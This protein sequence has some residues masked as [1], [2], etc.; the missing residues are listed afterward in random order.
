LYEIFALT[1]ESA[2]I[3][4]DDEDTIEKDDIVA[5]MI[6]YMS[7]FRFLREQG[8]DWFK[9]IDA[10][11]CDGGVSGLHI[12]KYILLEDIRHALDMAKNHDPLGK[13]TKDGTDEWTKRKPKLTA[14][15]EKCIEWC[16][17]TDRDR[18]YIFFS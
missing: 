9:L 2:V 6:T 13:L 16:V 10:Q 18:I 1:D 3:F 15:M 5:T 17:S 4:G 12:G 14:F 8:Y 11:E 7:A